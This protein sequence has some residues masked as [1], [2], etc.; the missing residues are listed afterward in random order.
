MVF[1]IKTVYC[2]ELLNPKTMKL[3]DTTKTNI[4][5]DEH[6][7]NLSHLEIKELV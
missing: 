5:T 6:G 1:D 7:E 4:I 2:L 3:L